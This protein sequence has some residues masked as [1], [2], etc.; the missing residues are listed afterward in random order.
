MIIKVSPLKKLSASKGVSKRECNVASVEILRRK[1]RKP[2][3]VGN[4]LVIISVIIP[5]RLVG[6]ALVNFKRQA[7]KRLQVVEVQRASRRKG[8]KKGRI[9][10]DDAASI[11]EHGRHAL[12]GFPHHVSVR[13]IVLARIGRKSTER[14]ACA[15]NRAE[16]GEDR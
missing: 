10:P 2:S 16:R 7:H 5:S 14:G 9:P 11:S 8:A 3:W 13:V 4:S 15:G 1:R 6:Q 12:V